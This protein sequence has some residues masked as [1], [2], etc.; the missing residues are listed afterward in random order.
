MNANNSLSATTPVRDTT[1]RVAL[2]WAES[3]ERAPGGAALPRD[4]EEHVAGR[5]AG[6]ARDAELPGEPTTAC[7]SWLSSRIYNAVLINRRAQKRSNEWKYAFP[8]QRDMSDY[9]MLKST[10]GNDRAGRC[11]E[12][13]SIGEH[14]LKNW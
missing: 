14:P 13:R 1:P 8:S 2:D 3:P 4:R 11:P 7:T 12:R 10:I 5:T 6:L 9:W